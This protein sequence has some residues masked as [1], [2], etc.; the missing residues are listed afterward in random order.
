MTAL[1]VAA[2]FEREIA[3]AESNYESSTYIAWLASLR[4]E[5]LVAIAPQDA[6]V[7]A[8][9]HAIRHPG[10]D[11]Q[12]HRTVMARHRQEWP[13]LWRALDRLLRP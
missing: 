5:V 3:T 12:R 8:V 2:I 6:A 11:P 4:D 10:P 13:V 9:W 7:H 1:E